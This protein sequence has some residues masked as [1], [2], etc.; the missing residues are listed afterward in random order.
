MP[1]RYCRAIESG[2]SG[3][4]RP[5]LAEPQWLFGAI[6]W[7][8]ALRT[9]I[10]CLDWTWTFDL[11]G[12]YGK[13]TS[14]KGRE[15]GEAKRSLPSPRW[16][17]VA[18]GSMCRR[19]DSLMG[20][21]RRGSMR[22]SEQRVSPI[23][24]E[25][26][27][28]SWPPG[29]GSRVS[30]IGMD[31]CTILRRPAAEAPRCSHCAFRPLGRSFRSLSRMDS[32]W[33]PPFALGRFHHA[34]DFCSRLPCHLS[35]P[36]CAGGGST[37]AVAHS[38]P[39][40]RPRSGWPARRRRLG[41]GA[42]AEPG[43]PLAGRRVAGA[44]RDGGE[45]RRRGCRAAAAR[46]DGG[47]RPSGSPAVRGRVPEPAAAGGDPVAAG[48]DGEGR[49]TG[50]RRRSHGDRSERLRVMARRGPSRLVRNLAALH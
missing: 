18:T 23:G 35:T 27:S 46:A 22:S 36:W 24:P 42:P 39:T 3:S 31:H 38:G 44:Q 6:C 30:A 28:G 20:S 11:F 14:R 43:R 10:V 41:H 17:P 45:R 49:G 12:C 48:A 21:T 33:R 26:R 37:G 5:W 8:T 4:R 9:G 13:A 2:H 34:I 50:S 29:P 7:R 47:R 32:D 25:E 1:G 19:V 40:R 16:L 15:S